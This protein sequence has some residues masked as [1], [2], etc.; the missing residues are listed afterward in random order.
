[1]IID[2][3]NKP[4]VTDYLQAFIGPKHSFSYTT[5]H[6]VTKL[7]KNLKAPRPCTKTANG[8]RVH[9]PKQAYQNKMANLLCTKQHQMVS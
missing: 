4:M 6:S 2:N 8:L 9:K 1:M 5:P 7:P 3:N